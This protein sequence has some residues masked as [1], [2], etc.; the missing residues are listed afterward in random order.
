MKKGKWRR[1]YSTDGKLLYQGFTLHE[2]PYGV[3]KAYYENGKVYQEGIFGLKGLICGREYYPDGSIRFEGEY[4]RSVGYGTNYPNYGKCFSL[5]KKQIVYEGNVN[6]Y[7]DREG[8]PIVDYPKSFVP[9]PEDMKPQLQYFA[10]DDA[11]EEK[12]FTSEYNNIHCDYKRRRYNNKAYNIELQPRPVKENFFQDF[13]VNT[14]I[15]LRDVVGEYLSIGFSPERD[16]NITCIQTCRNDDNYRVEVVV[17]F[18]DEQAFHIMALDNVSLDDTIKHFKNVC[19]DFNGIN[20]SEWRDVSKEV[21]YSKD[22]KEKVFAE[23][24]VHCA[25]NIFFRTRIFMKYVPSVDGNRNPKHKKQYSKANGWI[26]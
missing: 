5:E 20:I 9:I 3:G 17:N 4:S 25:R 1:L 7:L 24:A 19:V 15:N 13:I 11:A 10:W 8:S 23:E 18:H 22:D 14:I 26:L 2:K 12:I 6:T 16:D 21:N